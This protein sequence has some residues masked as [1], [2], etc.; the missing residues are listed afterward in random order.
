[1]ANGGFTIT[2]SMLSHS[3]QSQG[4]RVLWISRFTDVCAPHRHFHRSL[5]WA[6][7]AAMPQSHRAIVASAPTKTSMPN[8]SNIWTA[9]WSQPGAEHHM[10]ARFWY[11]LWRTSTPPLCSLVFGITVTSF[12]SRSTRVYALNPA[13]MSTHEIIDATNSSG[14]NTWLPLFLPL[15]VILQRL[16][17][18]A[19][20]RA[21]IINRCPQSVHCKDRTVHILLW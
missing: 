21:I 13:K 14:R 9:F 11:E 20:I 4:T 2:K 5:P 8:S 7:P 19:T 18:Y 12:A 1:M 6:A 10:S 3:P 15:L 17:C 16:P